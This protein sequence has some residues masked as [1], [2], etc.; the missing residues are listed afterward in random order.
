ML[1]HKAFYGLPAVTRRLVAGLL[2][3]GST[4]LC[5]AADRTNWARCRGDSVAWCKDAFRPR[6]AQGHS[7]GLRRGPRHATWSAGQC[8]SGAPLELPPR[9]GCGGGGVAW[10]RPAAGHSGPGARDARPATHRRL[11]RRRHGGPAGGLAAPGGAAAAWPEASGASRGG[12]CV[13][14]WRGTAAEAAFCALRQRL[15]HGWIHRPN[16]RLR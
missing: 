12:L 15:L 14:P 3:C 8:I 4:S 5:G 16:G 13:T 9:R 11:R 10:P 1:W 2:P 7:S 6:S